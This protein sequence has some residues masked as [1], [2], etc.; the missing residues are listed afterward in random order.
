MGN[1]YCPSCGGRIWRLSDDKFLKCHRC[2]WTVSY[3]VL[4]WFTHPTWIK[5]YFHRLRNYPASTIWSI[6]KVAIVLFV[7]GVLLTGSVP[8]GGIT[9]SLESV[10]AGGS[11]GPSDDALVA[12]GYDLN[13]TED[14]F[15]QYLNKERS[16]RGLQNVSERTVLTEMGR[17][18]SRD[19]AENGYFAH[20]EPDGD[21]IEDRY[22]QRSLLPECRLPIADTDRY[23]PG[24]ENI[25]KT[26]VGEEV[27]A[28][29]AEGGSYTVDNERELAKALVQTWM[30]SQEHREAMLVNSADQ[31]GLGVYITDDGAVYASLELC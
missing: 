4:R 16:N 11:N 24:A 23:Y 9:E 30:H 19:M 17:A 3:P 28:D 26:H 1:R 29:W 6:S 31:A 10:A 25:A 13:E 27:I 18:H 15:I 22:R 12:E 5:Y 7:A 21:T 2:N 8:I 14:L 20:E